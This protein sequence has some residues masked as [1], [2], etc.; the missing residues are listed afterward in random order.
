M[1][2]IKA[3]ITQM[4]KELFDKMPQIYVTTEDGN[5]QILFEFYPDEITFT[6]DEF[7]G[8][9]IDEAKHLKFEKDK[10]YIQS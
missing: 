9:T 4:P 3:R 7:I 1:K 10:K 6:E 2:I 8:L 5:E